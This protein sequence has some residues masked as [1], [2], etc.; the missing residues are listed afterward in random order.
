LTVLV[1]IEEVTQRNVM[2][3]PGMRKMSAWV[4]ME[5]GQ[6]VIQEE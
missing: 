1:D 3:H 4:T 5:E 6:L 2:T